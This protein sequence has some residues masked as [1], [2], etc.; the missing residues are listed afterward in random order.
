MKATGSA[1][2]ALG[3]ETALFVG[4]GEARL[5]V[6]LELNGDRW[7]LAS[8]EFDE[9]GQ[10]DLKVKFNGF[11]TRVPLESVRK[12]EPVGGA[13]VYEAVPKKERSMDAL[14]FC[15]M[16]EIDGMERKQSAWNRRKE[17]R[18]DVGADEGRLEAFGLKRAEQ[19]LVSRKAEKPCVVNNVSFSGAQITAWADGYEEGD[20]ASLC[21]SFKNPI[22]FLATRSKVVSARTVSVD[23]GRLVS[24]VSLRH[25]DCPVEYLERVEK[26]GDW[27]ESRALP[28]QA[29]DA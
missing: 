16:Q 14:G 17:A 20:D 2:R 18:W 9:S 1:L 24:V 6:I 29:A 4:N 26:F 23:E 19:S 28:L 11:F 27:T 12:L 22:Q 21:L 3:I 13:F 5:G 10:W 7:L 8:E 25:V 15:L